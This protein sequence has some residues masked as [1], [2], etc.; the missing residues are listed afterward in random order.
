LDLN[1]CGTCHTMP[2]SSPPLIHIEYYACTKS[3][4]RILRILIDLSFEDLKQKLT[5]VDTHNISHKKFVYN[6]YIF[7][8]YTN[9]MLIYCINQSFYFPLFTPSSNNFVILLLIIFIFYNLLLLTKH[10]NPYFNLYFHP[11]LR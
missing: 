2:C 3:L 6:F 8:L 11:F 7:F 5:F 9:W 10:H 1:W 4:F